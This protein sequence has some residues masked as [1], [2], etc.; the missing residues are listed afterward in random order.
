[1]IKGR[2]LGRIG[3][4]VSLALMAWGWSAPQLGR[5][6]E[7]TAAV[8]V[9]AEAEVKDDKIYAVDQVVITASKTE[10]HPDDVRPA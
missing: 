7:Q 2:I 8:T 6:E 4:V 1:M 5:A 9:P 3:F 10:R